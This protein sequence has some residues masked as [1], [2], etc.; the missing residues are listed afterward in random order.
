MSLLNPFEI[1]CLLKNAETTKRK[2]MLF[3]IL[4]KDSISSTVL[5]LLRANRPNSVH[6]LNRVTPKMAPNYH[7]II[8][9]PMDLSTIGKIRTQLSY[10]QLRYL[11]RLIYDNCDRYNYDRRTG[12]GNQVY[13]AGCEMK[14]KTDQIL[15][16]IDNKLLNEIRNTRGLAVEKIAEDFLGERFYDSSEILLPKEIDFERNLRIF[17]A[18]I[19]RKMGLKK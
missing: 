16:A 5:S 2:T 7:E 18:E 6:F 9:W 17:V 3:R 13:A 11:L 10:Q 4:N 19:L 8:E 12:M 15:R 1:E 14:R